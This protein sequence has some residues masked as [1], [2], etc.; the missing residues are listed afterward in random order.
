MAAL[1]V[2]IALL[3]PASE[4]WPSVFSARIA[5]YL[6]TR[7]EAVAQVGALTI[8]RRP[9]EVEGDSRDLANAIA[10]LRRAAVE[11]DILGPPVAGGL[12]AAISG[13]LVGSD[14]ARLLAEIAAV[15]PDPFA[16]EINDRYPGDE[17]LATTPASLLNALPALPET[18]AY[19]FVGRDLLLLDRNARLIVDVARQALPDETVR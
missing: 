13:R 1:L 14:G 18:L 4:A 11:G 7:A 12:R 6:S 16:V 15:Q 10:G 19:R 17:P 9:A 8:S 5:G 3:L 2:S